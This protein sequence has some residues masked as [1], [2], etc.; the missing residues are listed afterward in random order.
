[1]LKVNSFYRTPTQL[2]YITSYDVTTNRYHGI[3]PEGKVW[4]R[5]RKRDEPQFIYSG[6]FVF[7]Q[8]EEIVTYMQLNYPEYFI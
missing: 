4:C 1:M 2:I 8:P 7:F 6:S 5:I 3:S